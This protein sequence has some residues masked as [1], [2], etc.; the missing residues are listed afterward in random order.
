M[1]FDLAPN[2]FDVIAL[3]TLRTFKEMVQGHRT[4]HF[5]GEGQLGDDCGGMTPRLQG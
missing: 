1:R 2:S 4:L 3:N 5:V